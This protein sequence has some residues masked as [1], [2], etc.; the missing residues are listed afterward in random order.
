MSYCCKS[1]QSLSIV[2]LALATLALLPT[3]VSAGASNQNAILT[4]VNTIRAQYRLPLLQLHPSLQQAASEQAQLM[5]DTGKMAHKV[6]RG[7][8]FKARLKRVGYRG[9]AAENIAHGQR[10]LGRVLAGWMKSPGHRRNML[11]PRMRYFGLAAAKNGGR[12][13]WAM[14]L[15]G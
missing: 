2:L 13:Y 4:A 11:H 15:G 10:S 7:E 14:V 5:A 9:L 12:P 1:I 3:S 6:R 8:G